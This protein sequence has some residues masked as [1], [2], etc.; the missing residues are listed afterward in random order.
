MVTM[1]YLSPLPFAVSRT[2]D[3]FCTFEIGVCST[4]MILVA[5]THELWFVDPVPRDDRVRLEVSSLHRGL[6]PVARRLLWTH[7][8]NGQQV[9]TA[10]QYLAEHLW[11]IFDL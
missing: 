6:R 9:Y 5:S 8:S 3:C 7:G 4:R 1:K 2:T 11:W 10:K